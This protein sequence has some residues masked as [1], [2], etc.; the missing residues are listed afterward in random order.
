[1]VPWAACSSTCLMYEAYLGLANCSCDSSVQVDL[2]RHWALPCPFKLGIDH[3]ASSLLGFIFRGEYAISKKKWWAFKGTTENGTYCSI[4]GD[5]GVYLMEWGFLTEEA[6]IMRVSAPEV[7][8]GIMWRENWIIVNISLIQFS[9]IPKLYHIHAKNKGVHI[10]YHLKSE[11]L[12]RKE[13]VLMNG[14]CSRRGV[15]KIEW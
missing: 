8:L 2:E 1:M 13:S 9:V 14:L 7:M 5:V 10:L 15:W 6:V 3:F 12:N 4:F 11:R